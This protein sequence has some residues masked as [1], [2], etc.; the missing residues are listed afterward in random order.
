MNTY[1]PTPTPT[2]SKEEQDR[3]SISY[4][5]LQERQRENLT[6]A[7]ELES[8]KKKITNQ[9]TPTIDP[10]KN[11]QLVLS[12]VI[13][14][15]LSTSTPSK[16]AASS[17]PKPSKTAASSTPKPTMKNKAMNTV[18]SKNNSLILTNTLLT[19]K[20]NSRLKNKSTSDIRFINTN[21]IYTNE[22]IFT[23]N[24]VSG[25]VLCIFSIIYTA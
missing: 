24:L 18:E 21:Y 16:T 19:N 5:L 17:T 13:K 8:A 20:L 23:A 11:A 6:R 2:K 7:D 3:E 14:N 4:I 10:L 22:I 9:P 25:I 15:V 1:T 12:T